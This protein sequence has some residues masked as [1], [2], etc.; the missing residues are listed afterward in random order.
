MTQ[1]HSLELV[2][3]ADWLFNLKPSYLVDLQEREF[4]LY[5]SLERQ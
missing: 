3:M 2:N 5:I 1:Q 4:E